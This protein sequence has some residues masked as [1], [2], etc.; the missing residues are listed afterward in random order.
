[1]SNELFGI[2]LYGWTIHRIFRDGNEN[3][4][5]ITLTKDGKTKDFVEAIPLPKPAPK[6]K[7]KYKIEINPPAERWEKGEIIYWF[8]KKEDLLK[9]VENI[10]KKRTSHEV[11]SKG[12]QAIPR[13]GGEF[14]DIQ[15]DQFAKLIGWV[16]PD[17]KRVG[18]SGSNDNDITIETILVDPKRGVETKKLRQRAH[19]YRCDDTHD[20][21]EGYVSMWWD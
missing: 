6:P 2:T 7:A 17:A 14:I 11:S 15:Y 10:I 8:K 9:W 21:E 16:F 3:I 12:T 19:I 4:I 1:M 18:L 5:K 13:F 20:T